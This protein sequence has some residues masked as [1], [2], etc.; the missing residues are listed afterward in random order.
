MMV[1]RK[2]PPL[3]ALRAFEC[4]ARHLSFTR[5]GQE[6]LVTQGAISRQVRVL[7][8][9]LG[10]RVFVRLT[11][12]I[13]LTEEGARYFE[14][15]GRALDD[16]EVATQDLRGDSRRHVMRISVLPTISSFWLMPR[17]AAFSQDQL[18]ADVRI[19]NSI[20]PVD[21]QAK[22]TDLAIRVGRVPGEEYD[23]SHPRI[24][25]DMVTDWRGVQSDLLFPDILVPVCSPALLQEIG[26]LNSIDDLSRHRLIHV[27]TRRHAWHDWLSAHGS[28]IDPDQNALHFGHFF[29]AME[30]ARSG[31]G[32]AIVPTV[33]VRHYEAVR[34]VVFPF[35]PDI[36]S[37]GNY[38]LLFHESRAADPHVNLFRQWLVREASKEREREM[39]W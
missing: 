21:F 30:A 35:R 34:D 27:T 26:P 12:K 23:A 14:R 6:L 11:R 9:F 13:A 10:A 2:L 38:H 28:A 25:M 32:I 22:A 19:I 4:A 24:E 3:G 33:L 37:A 31:K 17:L 7:E 18:N 20:E 39:G 15:I 8:E 36:R 16:V 1:R 5:A 29:M